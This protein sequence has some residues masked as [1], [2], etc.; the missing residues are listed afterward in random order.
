MTQMY[1]T[2][3]DRKESRVRLAGCIPVYVLK[4]GLPDTVRPFESS[5]MGE[6]ALV[7]LFTLSLTFS[8]VVSSPSPISPLVCVLMLQSILR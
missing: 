4:V 6:S 5:D 3:I 2:I 8:V 1:V 7:D